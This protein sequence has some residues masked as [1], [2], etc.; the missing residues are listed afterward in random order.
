[1]TVARRDP[2]ALEGAPPRGAG[3]ADASS[4]RIMHRPGDAIVELR[5]A[6][7]ALAPAPEPDAPDGRRAAL[8]DGDPSTGDGPRDAAELW[9]LDCVERTARARAIGYSSA[10]DAVLSIRRDVRLALEA[11]RLRPAT[12]DRLLALATERALDVLFARPTAD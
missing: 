12:R 8:A 7:S 3:T 11:E 10:A 9:F 5:Q 2:A 4:R 6:A 1:M